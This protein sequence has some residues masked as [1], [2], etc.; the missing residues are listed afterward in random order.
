VWNVHNAGPVIRQHQLALTGVPLTCLDLNNVANVGMTP[1]AYVVTL[2]SADPMHGNLRRNMHWEASP[3][4]I[5]AATLS[6]CDLI[7]VW[8]APKS[9]H[10]CGAVRR[11][12]N[13]FIL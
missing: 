5:A 1:H 9:N 13:V 10:G 4:T 7:N 3:H 2:C 8:K 11:H 6:Y 12:Y